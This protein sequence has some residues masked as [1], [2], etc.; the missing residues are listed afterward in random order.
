MIRYGIHPSTTIDS[1]GTLTL[2]ETTVI[3][4]GS[5]LYLGQNGKLTLGERNT[6]YPM[7][8]IRIDQGWM[9]TGEDVSI[10]SGTHIYEP[11]AGLEIGARCLIAG[12]CM[13]C[14]VEHGYSRIDIPMREQPAHAKKITI[15]EDVWL[16]M[17][18][19]ICPGVT[20]GRGSVIGAG[21]VVTKDIPEYSVAYGTP[22]IVK[23][24]RQKDTTTAHDKP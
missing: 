16:G 9:T 19:I 13:I 18:V 8:S 15:G 21:S 20:I 22:C 5:I 1:Q 10:G 7:V 24:N 14:G 23:R 12:G 11:R 17:G 2:P 3:E 4:P 6:I